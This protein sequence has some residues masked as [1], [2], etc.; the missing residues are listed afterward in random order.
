MI[1]I[2]N[3]FSLKQIFISIIISCP[4]ISITIKLISLDIN[5]NKIILRLNK[6]L[7]DYCIFIDY[8]IIIII[9]ILRISLYLCRLVKLNL[10]F[11]F[12]RQIIHNFALCTANVLI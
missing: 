4:N 11:F 9:L 5:Y 12:L 10:I 1:I 8:T 2:L 7:E 3:N 6:Y